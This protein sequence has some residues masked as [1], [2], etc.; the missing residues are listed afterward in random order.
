MMTVI[1]ISTDPVKRAI[2]TRLGIKDDEPI[3]GYEDAELNYLEALHFDIIESSFTKADDTGSAG[4]ESLLHRLSQESLSQRDLG[5]DEARA[6]LIAAILPGDG[7]R[8]AN[9]LLEDFTEKLTQ[10]VTS[11]TET[12]TTIKPKDII[13]RELK[14]IDDSL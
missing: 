1:S 5:L 7:G 6:A 3:G 10:F 14:L 12:I 2:A 4:A 13:A 8:G 9:A 11:L